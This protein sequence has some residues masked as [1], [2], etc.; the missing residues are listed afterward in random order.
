MQRIVL[1]EQGVPEEVGHILIGH[2][3]VT[4]QVSAAVHRKICRKQGVPEEV[5]HV[6][7]GHPSV[8]G[9]VTGSV[10]GVFLSAGGA[11]TAVKLMPCGRNNLRSHQHFAAGRTMYARGQTCCGAGRR[12][13]LV[14]DFF[15][16][17]A[18][19]TSATVSVAL[20]LLHLAVFVPS[21]V[22]VA[23]FSDT[24]W[25]NLWGSVLT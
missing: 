2:L 19:P 14:S 12:N 23:F 9:K 4:G 15:V 21:S 1:R 18:L 8:S 22:Q 25:P 7:I 3:T 11:E 20:Q 17:L 6:L 5:S 24:Y 16:P 10:V 13:R